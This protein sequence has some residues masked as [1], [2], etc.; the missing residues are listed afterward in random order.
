MVTESTGRDGVHV[1]SGCYQVIF[2]VAGPGGEHHA[3]SVQ[4]HVSSCRSRLVV[5]ESTGV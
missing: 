5:S 4:P 1:A 2:Q 3:R